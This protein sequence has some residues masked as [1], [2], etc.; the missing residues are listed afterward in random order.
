MMLAVL[1]FLVGSL[2][3]CRSLVAQPADANLAP[4]AFDER[5]RVE[6]KHFLQ[7]LAYVYNPALWISYNDSLYFAAPTEAQLRQVEIMKADR[8][9]YVALT[10]RVVRHALAARAMAESGIG[11]QWQ[12]KL[13]LPYSGANPNLTPTLGRRVL[14]VPRYQ[15]LQSFG[16]GDALV[17]TE[18]AT[19]FVMNFGRGKT[20][21]GCTN[22]LWIKEGM[23]T[24]GA[25]T[26][27]TKTVEAYTSASLNSAEIAVLTRVAL[28]FQRE[29]TALDANAG[30]RQ[31]FE[32]HKARATDG[33]P[34]MEY[35]LA[36]DYLDG[37]GTAQDQTLGLDWMRRAAKSGSGDAQTYLEK[38]GQKAPS[39]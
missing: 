25:P 28:A 37:N 26:G 29:A 36:K 38:S 9:R 39:P 6:Q 21:A 10:N 23:K 7:C 20:D 27:E 8:E 15:L 33:N 35:L 22:G 17:Q 16:A 14:A 19:C 12:K 1:G 24:Y 2:A 11:E 4:E 3:L 30:A 32:D 5:M 34:Y 13:L 31:D 18:G